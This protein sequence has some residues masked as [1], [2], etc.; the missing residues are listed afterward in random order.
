MSF[1]L[2][3]LVP[4]GALRRRGRTVTSCVLFLALAIASRYAFSAV[5]GTLGP[6]PVSAG[7]AA[8]P[9]GISEA[10][11]RSLAEKISV[12]TGTESGRAGSYQPVVITQDEAN[13]YL[14]Y[15]GHEFLPPGIHD[16]ALRIS[17]AGVSAAGDVDFNEL[18]A[19]E[20]QGSDW[21]LKLLA[22]IFRGKQRVS[23]TG[24]LETGNGQGKVMIESLTIGTTSIPAGFVNFLVQ[25][26]MRRRYNVD[27][28]KPFALPDRV[29]HIELGT[30][31]A[32]FHRSANR[33]R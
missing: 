23:A 20:R 4:R 16:P 17:P 26:Y 33:S 7:S 5:R 3:Y 22:L 11:A 30:G 15:R 29:T 9:K 25:S 2:R 19:T 8:E 13:S 27:L 14:K 31:G 24:K 28:S 12:L 10:A 18:G 21:G 1:F 6:A 32:T